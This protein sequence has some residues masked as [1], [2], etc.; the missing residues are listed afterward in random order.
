[1]S[2]SERREYGLGIAKRPICVHG[3]QGRG[4]K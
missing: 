2:K 4:N 1:M 3:E